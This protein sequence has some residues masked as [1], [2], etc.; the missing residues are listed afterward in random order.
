MISSSNMS[1][2]P[3][4]ISEDWDVIT[5]KEQ[6]EYVVKSCRYK[7][8][9]L[10]DWF[11]KLDKEFKDSYALE[12]DQFDMFMTNDWPSSEQCKKFNEIKEYIK[13]N[14]KVVKKRTDN[15]DL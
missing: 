11:L 15:L 13:K 8:V 14:T 3:E 12:K 7:G 2:S 1:G 4:S 10:L 6:S 9:T 5:E